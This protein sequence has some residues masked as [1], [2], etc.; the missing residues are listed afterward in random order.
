MAPRFS[1]V[2]ETRN[3]VRTCATE[4][5]ARAEARAHLLKR[6]NCR[7]VHELANRHGARLRR[8]R[9]VVD[10]VA[11]LALDASTELEDDATAKE[12]LTQ[13]LRIVQLVR[14]LGINVVLC[15]QRFGSDMGKLITSIR[16]QVSG[17]VC[18]R[19]CDRQTAEMTLPGLDAEVHA[20]AMNLSRP[21]LAVV[22]SGGDTW[23]LARPPYRTF[24]DA[25][26]VALKYADKAIPLHQL[27]A[28]DHARVAHLL[29]FTT[30]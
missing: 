7:S 10:E 8:V 27:D 20:R 29:K 15:G 12:V 1:A 17:R 22:K 18:L 4:L 24:D 9:V 6:L 5:L 11:E 16:A 25:R 21:G 28:D 19:V 2:C 3:E 13:V 26:A 14:C 23:Y 30:D